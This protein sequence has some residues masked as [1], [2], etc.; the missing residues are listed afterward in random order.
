MGQITGVAESNASRVEP[1]GR[2]SK[3]TAPVDPAP[4]QHG[5]GVDRVELSETA[6]RVGGVGDTGLRTDLIERIRR[7]IEAGTYETP[8]RLEI[9]AERIA[10]VLDVQ[11]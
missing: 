8:E 10:R 2:R 1:V 6:K 11:G 9:T 3:D 4:S 5:R 7:E